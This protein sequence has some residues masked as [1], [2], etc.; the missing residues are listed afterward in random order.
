MLRNPFLAFALLASAALGIAGVATHDRPPVE[1]Q[2]TDRPLQQ[3]DAGFASSDVCRACHPSQ[4]ASWHASF[5]RTMTQVATPAS[6]LPDFD[7]QTVSAVHGRPMVLHTRGDT[8]WAEFDDPDSERPPEQRPRIERRVTLITGSHNQQIFWYATGHD[9]LLGQLPGAYLISERR[10]IP[11]R[12]AVLHPPSQAPLSETGHWNASC[13]ACHATNGKPQLETPFGAAPMTSQAIQTTATEFGIACEQCHGPSG[14]HVRAN[15]SLLR[16]YGLHLTGAADP[17]TVQPARLEPKRAS[18]VC[19]QCHAVWEFYDEAGERHANASGLPFRPGDELSASRFVAQPTVNASSPTMQA[20]LADDSRFIR[21]AF[22]PD[23]QVRVSGREYNGLIESPC[24]QRATTPERTLSCFSCHSLH[25]GDDDPRQLGEWADDQLAWPSGPSDVRAREPRDDDD[26]C[27]QCHEPMRATLSAHTHH[28]AS[29]SGSRCYNC[30][31][32]YT[33]YGLLKTIRSHTVSSP[34][35]RESTEAGRPNACNLCHLDRTLAWTSATLGEWYGAAAPVLEE[36]QKQVAASVLW[37]LE[38]D[39]GQRAIVS[40][41]MAWPAAQQTSGTDWMAPYLAQVLD[42]PYDAI[43]LGAAAAIRAV[44]GFSQ[45]TVDAIAAP[46]DRRRIQLNVMATWDRIRQ[47]PARNSPELLMTATGELD[48]ERVRAH[49][50]R[51]NTRAMLL[52]E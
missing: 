36:D 26:A 22:W 29:S 27:L 42:D 50:R 21:D 45:V 48:I 28:P 17:T 8:L 33:S 25:K 43:R 12:M 31:M 6:A 41:A 32:P 24:Y 5:H 44:P 35:V 11:R 18:Q 37:L 23:G 4:Y 9:R 7:D 47:R 20:L 34:T 10:W 30:H 16:R 15:Q 1:S 49:L 13:I 19:G 3:P 14:D 39:A 38:G 2:V 52:R 40:R 51:R 46:A